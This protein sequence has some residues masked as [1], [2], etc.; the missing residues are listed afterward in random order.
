MSWNSNTEPKDANG[1]AIRPGQ[2]YRVQRGGQVRLGQVF[3]AEDLTL[4]IQFASADGA[5]LPP[6][7]RVDE[8]SQFCSWFPVEP[9]DPDSSDEAP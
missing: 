3:E 1:E 9:S 6:R 2:F 4:M 7:Q 8:L 5:S